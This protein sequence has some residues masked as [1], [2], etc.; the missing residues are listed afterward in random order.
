MLV[1][2]PLLRALDRGPHPRVVGGQEAHD[3]HHEV[4][5]VQVLRVEGLRER[6]HTL[7]PPPVQDGAAYLLPRRTPA[8]YPVLI[9]LQ[10]VGHVD[11]PVQRDPAHELGVEEVAGRPPDLPDSLVLLLP[12][13][14]RGVRQVREEGAGERIGFDHVPQP[15]GGVHELAVDVQLALI[16]RPVAHPNRPAVAP[17]AEVRQLPLAQVVLAADP[18]HDLELAA[19]TDLEQRVVG[20]EVEEAV[21]IIRTGGHPEGSQREAGIADP[22]VSIIPVAGSA[23]R[24]G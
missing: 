16:P 18:E 9:R 21:G 6:A 17:P 4:R 20:Q 10:D 15:V 19:A 8:S 5:G 23:H 1:R 13:V 22:C 24:L 11:G 14:R 3:R 2:E 7:V 12:A